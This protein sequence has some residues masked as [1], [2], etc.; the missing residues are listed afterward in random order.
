MQSII[1]SPSD[2]FLSEFVTRLFERAYDMEG[3][4][5]CSIDWWVKDSIDEIDWSYS[6]KQRAYRIV[7]GL[8]S[9]RY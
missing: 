4:L 2:K 6:D 8:N 9:A 7:G 3:H 5:P 1:K